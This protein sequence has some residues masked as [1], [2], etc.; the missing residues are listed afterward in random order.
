M[1]WGTVKDK[2]KSDSIYLSG[3]SGDV[4][5]PL[6]ETENAFNEFYVNIAH[7]IHHNIAPLTTNEES[8]LE[9]AMFNHV[10]NN[11]NITTSSR[12]F[13]FRD[14]THA[15]VKQLVKSIQIHK[16]SGMTGITSNLFKISAKILIPQLKFPF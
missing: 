16:S 10:S 9:N 4:D 7:R 3:S 2:K 8:I 13:I 6:V 14:V 12:Q 5:L 11:T 1:V 15:E